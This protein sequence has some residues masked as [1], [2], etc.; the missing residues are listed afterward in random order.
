V[1]LVCNRIYK[2][3]VYMIFREKVHLPLSPQ[4]KIKNAPIDG[5]FLFYKLANT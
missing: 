2:Q 3:L 5:A 4:M 1:T